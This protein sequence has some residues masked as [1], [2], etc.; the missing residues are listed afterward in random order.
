MKTS[1]QKGILGNTELNVGRLGVAASY[2]APAKAFEEAFEKGCNYFY[3]GSG[4]RRAGMRQAV[5]NIVGQGQRDRLIVA[6][7]TYARFGF[8]TEYTFHRALRSMHLEY[9][10]ILILGWHNRPP[11][12][13]ILNRAL[14]LKEKGLIRH[15]GMS[16]HNRRLFPQM[17]KENLFD[18]FHIR[19]NAAHRGA[20]EE[21]FPH[22]TGEDRAGI[23]TYTATR[24][25]QLLD[26]KKMPSGIAA[27]TPEDCYRFV[28]SNPAVDVCMCGPKDVGQM[29]T[30]LS[31]LDLGP[32]VDDD[33]KRIKTIG[34][35]V[36]S[37]ARGFFG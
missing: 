1:F 14:A 7:Q 10:D 25:G 36:R 35:H 33:M 3:I 37:T 2:G 21:S 4:K 31:A 30:A 32:L 12:R 28:L 5:R 24:W 13:M 15:L 20:E 34:D 19:Y 23:V 11:S 17:V 26:P 9:A 22:L 27:L 29:Q 6:I 16:G 18:V 8:L